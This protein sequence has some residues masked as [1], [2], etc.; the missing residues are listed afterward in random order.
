ML[1]PSATSARPAKKSALMSKPVNGSAVGPAVA[2][3]LAGTV[4]DELAVGVM[5]LAAT[6]PAVGGEAAA[7]DGGEVL[8]SAPFPVGKEVE[9][10]V[11]VVVGAGIGAGVTMVVD[12]VV[13]DVHV[14]GMVVDEVGEQHSFMVP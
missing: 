6:E 5:L 2:G 11:V 13:V 3:R 9:V 1:R 7:A 14:G 4:A 10:V 8:L 12:V